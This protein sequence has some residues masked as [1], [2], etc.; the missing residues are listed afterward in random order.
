MEIAY[1]DGD[2]DCFSGEGFVGLDANRAV[3]KIKTNNNWG[4]VIY[5][6]PV[7]PPK[8]DFNRNQLLFI[9]PGLNGIWM[10]TPAP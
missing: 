8:V 5:P 7:D 1:K 2:T 3:E 9:G 6:G 10:N 4:S